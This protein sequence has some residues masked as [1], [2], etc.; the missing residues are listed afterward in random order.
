MRGVSFFDRIRTRAFFRNLLGGKRP[1]GG[2]AKGRPPIGAWTQF[3]ACRCRG[4]S[5]GA[6]AASAPDAL[7]TCV[8]IASIKAGERQS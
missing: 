2:R 6:Q 4:R 7:A 8:A 1:T 5:H 3:S